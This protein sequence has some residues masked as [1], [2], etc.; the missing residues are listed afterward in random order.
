MGSVKRPW[1]AGAVAGAC[2]LGGAT[3]ANASVWT[4]NAAQIDTGVNSD[5]VDITDGPTVDVSVM[6][7]RTIKG[8]TTPAGTI[9]RGTSGGVN[10]EI[11]VNPDYM[12]FNFDTNVFLDSL[13]IAWL[14]PDGE[15]GDQGDEVAVFETYG[16]N[17]VP[18]A[19]APLATFYLRAEDLEQGN[20]YH[21][22]LFTSMVNGVTVTNLEIAQ[23]G[24]P[25]PKSGVVW[26]I[27]GDNIFGNFDT[28]RMFGG[29]D[30]SEPA[31]GNA[32]SD[33]SFVS[34]GGAAVVPVPPA[35]PL[36][37]TG[38]GFLGFLRWR[39]NKLAA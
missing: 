34:A 6:P 24:N 18:G 19:D 3:A 37:A 5:T 29:D 21:D 23:D 36:L 9:T 4:L 13:E 1:I 11:D 20:L 32:D 31:G 17:A 33:F 38:L 8:K 39:R 7:N 27:A 15:Y 28:L 26:R 30:L 22:F 16:S 25:G 2:L 12:E 35:L 10:G 14:F